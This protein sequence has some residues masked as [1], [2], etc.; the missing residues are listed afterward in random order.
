MPKLPKLSAK[1]F[2]ADQLQVFSIKEAVRQKPAMY[3]GASGP[4]ALL[5]IIGQPVQEFLWADPKYR[6]KVDVE[7]SVRNGRQRVCI[8]FHDLISR[9]FDVSTVKTWNQRLENFRDQ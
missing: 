4:N 2:P 5:Y 9:V 3:F 7:C 8:I 1:Q 6:G